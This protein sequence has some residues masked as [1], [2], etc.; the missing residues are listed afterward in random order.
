MS[1]KILAF[2]SGASK[3][4]VLFTPFDSSENNFITLQSGFENIG[5]EFK[6]VIKQNVPAVEKSNTKQTNR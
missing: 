1:E 3:T 5:K 2:L 4:Y 6:K